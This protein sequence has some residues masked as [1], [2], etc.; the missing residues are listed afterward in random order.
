VG[1]LFILSEIYL[2]SRTACKDF[3]FSHIKAHNGINDSRSWVNNRL[4]KEAKNG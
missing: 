1:M 3:C 4:N 2:K